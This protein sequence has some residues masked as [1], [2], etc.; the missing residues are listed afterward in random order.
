MSLD[1][2]RMTSEIV[3]ESVTAST[4]SHAMIAATTQTM[5]TV[6]VFLVV[7]GQR[8]LAPE[9]CVSSAENVL[10]EP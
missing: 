4:T 6:V 9:N 1:Q 2:F 10:P 7:M 5:M 3:A 8:I